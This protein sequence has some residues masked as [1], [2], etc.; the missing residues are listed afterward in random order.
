MPSVKVSV[1]VPVHNTGKYIDECAPTLFRQ[2]LPADEYEV[3]YVDDG[4]TDDTPAR[5]DKIAAAHANVQVHT[6]PN[7]GWPGAP[8]NLGMRHANGEY[9]Q[10]VDHDDTLGPEALERLYEHARR[11]HADVVLGKM[12]S[13]MVRPRRLFR[14]TVDVCTIENDELM[15]SMS[16]H[17]MFRRAFVE[18]HALRGARSLPLPYVA[19]TAS[20]GPARLKVT[21]SA[22]TVDA[23]LV[24]G[25][26]G[27]AA[28]L[29]L[30]A[31]V[32]LPAG[33][34]PVTFPE[35][36]APVAHAVVRDGTLLRLEGPA[37]V[38]G[39]GRRLLDA[40][41]DNRQVRR[42]RRRLGRQGCGG[43]PRGSGLGAPS[44]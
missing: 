42:V 20:G 1:I 14:H 21:V 37:H 15:Q 16:P 36:G 7:S 24:P 5:L 17:K 18:Q 23:E 2:S 30:P 34:H 19:A 43:A 32:R 10:F 35:A 12:S 31:R 9:I 41:A 3:I 8:R 22:L 33:R 29:R 44:R 13:T 25:D 28:L 4:S 40:V 26:G 27:T 39:I 38:A 11:N 6:R